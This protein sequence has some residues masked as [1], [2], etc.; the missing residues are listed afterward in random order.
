MTIRPDMS[1]WQL[2]AYT[3]KTTK[4]SGYGMF[5]ESS[6]LTSC[7]LHVTHPSLRTEGESDSLQHTLMVFFCLSY[8]LTTVLMFYFKE[9]G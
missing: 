9:Y 7:T 6:M 4:G 5:W 2:L 8:N 3:R 1:A